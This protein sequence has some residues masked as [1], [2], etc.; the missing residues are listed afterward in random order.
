MTCLTYVVCTCIPRV[1]VCVGGGGEKVLSENDTMGGALKRAAVW[2]RRGHVAW[3]R[4]WLVPPLA[5]TEV[6]PVCRLAIWGA[7]YWQAGQ[8]AQQRTRMSRALSKVA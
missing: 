6:K 4:R 2:S 1:C 7:C 8:S 3:P 5:S